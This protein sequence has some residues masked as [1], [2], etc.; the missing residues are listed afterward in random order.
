MLNYQCSITIVRVVL[1]HQRVRCTWFTHL[2][3]MTATPQ[4][5]NKRQGRMITHTT[6]TAASNTAKL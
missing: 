5:A 4:R 1:A 3:D 6:M 2:K